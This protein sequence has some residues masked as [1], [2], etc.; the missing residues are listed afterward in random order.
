MRSSADKQV[1]YHSDGGFRAAAIN[2][3][4]DYRGNGNSLWQPRDLVVQQVGENT[5]RQPV[6]K[7]DNCYSC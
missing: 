1:K 2:G 4:A 6:W 5:E 3:E 7:A